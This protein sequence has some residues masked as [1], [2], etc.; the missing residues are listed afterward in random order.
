LDWVRERN[1]RSFIEAVLAGDGE[2]ILARAEKDRAA[3]SAG[4]VLGTLGFARERGAKGAELL[5]YGTSA[6]G[7]ERPPSSFVGYAALAWY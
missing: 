3:C 7:E 1:D 6:D 5:A 4:A 2:A